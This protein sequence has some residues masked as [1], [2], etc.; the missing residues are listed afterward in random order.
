CPCLI[1]QA[2]GLSSR[3]KKCRRQY[4]KSPRQ[5]RGNIDLSAYL[6]QMKRQRERRCCTGCWLWTYECV[7]AYCAPPWTRTLPQAVAIWLWLN[8]FSQPVVGE[9]HKRPE[10]LSF[11]C[12]A[13]LPGGETLR[14][15]QLAFPFVLANQSELRGLSTRK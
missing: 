6:G 14:L 8:L 9:F 13:S 11:F 4:Q 1:R 10:F 5:S 3:W 7:P 15:E 2:S 12:N